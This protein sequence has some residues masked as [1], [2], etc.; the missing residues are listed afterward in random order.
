MRKAPTM[1]VGVFVVVL[2]V[3]FSFGLLFKRRDPF[4]FEGLTLL[5]R[6]PEIFHRCEFIMPDFL[7][8]VNPS[9]HR[10]ASRRMI[11]MGFHLLCRLDAPKALGISV[12]LPQAMGWTCK[13]WENPIKETKATR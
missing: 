10:H 4:P 5:W 9:D 8:H 11:A 7:R 6:C 13:A 1:P 2:L 12:C 3:G